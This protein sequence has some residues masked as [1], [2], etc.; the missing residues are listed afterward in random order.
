MNYFS[1]ALPYNYEQIDELGE[2]NKSLSKSVIS[3]F[4]SA[5]PIG[6]EDNSGYEQNRGYYPEV[7]NLDEFLSFV[8]CFFKKF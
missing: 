1:V 4:Y 6:N 8:K 5:L 3:D 7:K 2:F